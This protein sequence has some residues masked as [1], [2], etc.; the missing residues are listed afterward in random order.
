[1]TDFS[2]EW[3]F[4]AVTALTLGAVVT[5]LIGEKISDLKLGNGTSL[6][7][8]TNIVSYLPSSIGRTVAQAVTDGNYPGLAGSIGAFLLLVLGIVYVQVEFSLLCELPFSF[9]VGVFVF[10]C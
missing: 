10:H 7:I 8:F 2:V 9:L 3:A 1:V 6:L 4:S 5:M